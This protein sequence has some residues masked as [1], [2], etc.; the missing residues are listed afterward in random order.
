MKLICVLRVSQ[1]SPENGKTLP[2]PAAELMLSHEKSEISQCHTAL[3][4]ILCSESDLEATFH[5]H[6]DSAKLNWVPCDS[7]FW[8]SQYGKKIAALLQ[9][10]A[11]D[12][13]KNCAL[14]VAILPFDVLPSACSFRFITKGKVNFLSFLKGNGGRLANYGWLTP[15]DSNRFSSP[16]LT[17]GLVDFR[18]SMLVS[19][20]A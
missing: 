6:G 7:V 20:G 9:D 14:S 15:S 5:F 18:I 4:P 16:V 17:W 13:G 2:F 11:W 10:V 3:L 1:F 12:E 19:R 8:D